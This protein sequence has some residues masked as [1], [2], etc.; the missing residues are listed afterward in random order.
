MAKTCRRHPV[1]LI[2]S[3]L[4]ILG[5]LALPATSVMAETSYHKLKKRLRKV[6]KATGQVL[7]VAGAIGALGTLVVLNCVLE[8]SDDDSSPAPDSDTVAIQAT[9]RPAK[10]HVHTRPAVHAEPHPAPHPIPHHATP[11]E[12]R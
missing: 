5:L 7:K 10:N 3:V 2:L 4:T 11:A 6:E 8:S 12:K 9:A 1:N